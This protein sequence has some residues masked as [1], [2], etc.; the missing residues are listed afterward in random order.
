MNKFPNCFTTFDFNTNYF[1]HL[2]NFRQL[3]VF[4]QQVP[5]FF[6]LKKHRHEMALLS[7]VGD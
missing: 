7:A 6:T 5:E 2:I 4:H 1:P 3:F